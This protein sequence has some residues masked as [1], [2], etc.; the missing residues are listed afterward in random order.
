MNTGLYLLLHIYSNAEGR[1]SAKT[2]HYSVA[3][4]FLMYGIT[5][6]L[7]ETRIRKLKLFLTLAVTVKMEWFV[8]GFAVVGILFGV[9]LL[10]V[11]FLFK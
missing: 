3:E 6:P 10:I 8:A 5:Y 2:L 9:F 11:P 1:S 4:R 7:L